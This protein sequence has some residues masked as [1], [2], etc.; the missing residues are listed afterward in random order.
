MQ[1]D[2]QAHGDRDL[3]QPRQPLRDQ[4]HREFQHR[5][6]VGDQQEERDVRQ[7]TEA[8]L[9]HKIEDCRRNY[10]HQQP[11]ESNE[12][13]YSG[14]PMKCFNCNED[15]HHWSVC[16]N[17]PFCYSCRDIGHKSNQCPMMRSNKGLRLC[18]YG[19]SG[20]LFYSLNLPEPKTEQR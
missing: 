15:G 13:Q 4:D 9:H 11:W 8:D 17:P 1:R 5:K 12:G 10:N 16:R 18:G 20:Q 19:M 14:P 7:M 2:T 6:R 3:R